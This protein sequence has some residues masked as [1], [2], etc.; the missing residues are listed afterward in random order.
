MSFQ[1]DSPTTSIQSRQLDVCAGSPLQ[2]PHTSSTPEGPFAS[3]GSILAHHSQLERQQ[4]GKGNESDDPDEIP[5]D[6][7]KAQAL[8]ATVTQQ[9]CNE[10]SLSTAEQRMQVSSDLGREPI[11]VLL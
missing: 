10:S 2:A 9:P 5:A 1:A 4:A 3:A 11:A 6:L 8:D 7:G